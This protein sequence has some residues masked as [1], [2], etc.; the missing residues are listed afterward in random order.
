MACWARRDAA[1]TSVPD[2]RAEVFG[3]DRFPDWI[4]LVGRAAFDRREPE[5]PVA[6][7]AVD[8]LMASPQPLSEVRT[9]RFA[10]TTRAVTVEVTNESEHVSLAIRLW[11]PAHVSVEVRPAHGTVQRVWSDGRGSAF[12]DA[13]PPGPLSL[14]VHW[15]PAA[16]GPLRTAWVQV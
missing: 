16:G 12:C 5:I 13:V 10:T 6:D 9:L 15:P 8:S 14:L 4:R 11:P 2:A 1:V 3:I 7:L